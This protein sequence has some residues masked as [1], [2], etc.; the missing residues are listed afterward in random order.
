[1]IKE[2]LLRL[3]LPGIIFLAGKPQAGDLDI[4]DE[5]GSEG[6][7][8]IRAPSRPFAVRLISQGK[9]LFL[10]QPIGHFQFGLKIIKTFGVRNSP[11]LLTD[12]ISIS[13]HKSCKAGRLAHPAGKEGE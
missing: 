13:F 4:E 5:V 1:M 12:L 8:K 2:G 7:R 3:L 11:D 10:K 9:A 6:D